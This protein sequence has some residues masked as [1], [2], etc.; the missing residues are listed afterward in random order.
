M[1]RLHPLLSVLLAVPALHAAV[2]L[3]D[4]VLYGTIAVDGRPVSRA[5]SDYVVEARRTASGPVLAS[6]RMGS[7]SRL[8]EFYYSLRLPVAELDAAPPTQAILGQSIVVTVRSSR[9]VAFQVVHQVTEPGVALRLDFGA[10]VD[11]DGDGVPEGWELAYLGS[12]HRNLNQDTDGDGAADRAEYFAG[13]RPTDATDT[14]RIAIQ[15]DTANLVVQFRALRALGA[16]F[17]ARTRFYSLEATD[18]PATGR[19]TPVENLSRVQGADQLVIHTRPAG[20]GTPVFFRARVWL[21]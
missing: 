15:R 7:V 9:G 11:A 19:W 16:G 12:I 18:D 21:E 3:P 1:K 17:E 5:D 8:G 4:H 6:Y 14:F 10:A 13:T 20:D 2:P